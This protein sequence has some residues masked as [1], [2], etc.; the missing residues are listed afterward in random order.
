MTLQ[1]ASGAAPGTQT[2]GSNITKRVSSE[3]SRFLQQN[4]TIRSIT[5][6]RA[7]L[8]NSQRI[9]PG[10]GR[11]LSSHLTMSVAA[12]GSVSEVVSPALPTSDGHLCRFSPPHLPGGAP[13]AADLSGLGLCV[14]LSP[15]QSLSIRVTALYL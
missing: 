6:F 12:P 15:G 9:P 10:T 2:R 1:D 13:A 7:L 4:Q 3:A 11:Y 8:R 14:R 5:R